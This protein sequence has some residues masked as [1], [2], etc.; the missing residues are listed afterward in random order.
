MVLMM[1]WVVLVMVV[2]RVLNPRLGGD[3]GDGADDA[4]GGAGVAPRVL[5]PRLGGD[6]GDGADDAAGGAGDGGAAGSAPA[7]WR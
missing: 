2:P 7:A 6:A 5:S 3:A 1:L 4:V